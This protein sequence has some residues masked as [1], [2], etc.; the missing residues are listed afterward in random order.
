MNR[1]TV[2]GNLGRN[3]DYKLIGEKQTPVLSFS[4]GVKPNWR[5]EYSKNKPTNWH[6]IIVWGKLAE[7]L[8]ARLSKG[9]RVFVD[10]EY[11]VRSYQGR[12]GSKKYAYEIVADEV[13][14]F[15]DGSPRPAAATEQFQDPTETPFTENDIPY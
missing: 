9:S 1:I 11:E 13:Q 5:G 8:S 10:G 3:P 4:L 7:L 12:D 2:I 6:R 15:S 14:V